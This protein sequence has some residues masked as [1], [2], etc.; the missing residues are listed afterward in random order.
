MRKRR[1]SDISVELWGS[2][3][4][5]SLLLMGDQ[6]LRLSGGLHGT[7]G[8]CTFN[9]FSACLYLFLNKACDWAA[10]E[11]AVVFLLLLHSHAKVLHFLR[12]W[13]IV[14]SA[15]YMTWLL[16]C[17]GNP[18]QTQSCWHTKP[19]CTVWPW[20][21]NTTLPHPSFLD[22][23]STLDP[24]LPL[25][26]ALLPLSSASSLWLCLNKTPESSCS[27]A[28]LHLYYYPA[29]IFSIHPSSSLFKPCWLHCVALT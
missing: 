20:P 26:P 21:V 16:F 3:L 13:L 22:F 23:L 7:I 29:T 10:D 5:G 6:S 15:V 28:F 9:S 18:L 1:R 8:M 11:G 14:Y 2:C 24:S 27:G 19:Q 25:S 17:S 4:Q 12:N